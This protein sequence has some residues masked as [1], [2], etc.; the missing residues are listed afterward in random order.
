[1]APSNHRQRLA[2]ALIVT[3]LTF[4]E[5]SISFPTS[6]IPVRSSFVS[7]YGHSPSARRPAPQAVRSPTSLMAVEMPTRPMEEEREH[8][9]EKREWKRVVGGFVPNFL[10]R[11]QSGASSVE[12]LAIEGTKAPIEAPRIQTIDTLGEYKLRVVDEPQK[13]VVVRF[14]AP[15]CKSCKAAE[16]LFKKISYQYGDEVNF[17]QVPLTKETAYIHEGLGVP[18]V[19]YGHIYHPEAGL[20]EEMKINKKVFGEFKAV[21]E[22]YINGECALPDE[23]V[24]FEEDGFQ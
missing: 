18:S 14:Y 15:W 1:M 22:D 4:P 3:I 17:V 5:N 12:E 8:E 21:L 9:K 16:P 13:L 20:V 7:E 2:S 10:K 11:N 6:P 23:E 24:E 19:P